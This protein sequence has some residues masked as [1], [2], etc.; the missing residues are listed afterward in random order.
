MSESNLVSYRVFISDEVLAGMKK[1]E[2]GAS[3]SRSAVFRAAMY[4]FVAELE[5]MAETGEKPI[6]EEGEGKGRNLMISRQQRRQLRSLAFKF[7]R[8]MA[9]VSRWICRRL[10]EFIEAGGAV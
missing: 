8:S 9:H 5:E 7:D 3:L 6:F 10:V 2:D 4:L 1:I